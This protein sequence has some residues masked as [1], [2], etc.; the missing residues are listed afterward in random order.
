MHVTKRTNIETVGVNVVSTLS[1]KSND[2]PAPVMMFT[3]PRLQTPREWFDQAEPGF[4]ATERDYLLETASCEDGGYRLAMELPTRY[5]PPEV[6]FAKEGDERKE[7]RQRGWEIIG[8]WFMSQNR[9]YDALAV[10]QSLYCH[11][12]L[13]EHDE[14]QRT[15]K[16]M[17]LIYM[18]ECF[19][20]LRHPVHSKRYLMYTLC[21]DAVQYGREKR[22]KG[23]GVYFR[24]VWHHGMSD[25]LVTEYTQL[26][27]DKAE[28]L[29]EEGWFPERLLAELEDDRWMTESPSEEEV[30]SY[31]CNH[32]YVNHLRA[33]LGSSSGKALE[34]LAH[35]LL[36]M[37][38]G[39]R[40][41]RRQLTPSTDYDVV[42]SFK[43]SGL[44][45]R[46]E[47]GRYF[48]CEYKDWKDPADFTTMA[49][50]A[51]VLDSVKSRFGILFS[52]NW[53]SGMGRTEDAAREQLKV[54]A[55]RGVAIVVVSN[56]DIARVASGEHFLAMIR[57]KYERVRLDIAQPDETSPVAKTPSKAK[58]NKK[59]PEK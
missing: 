54:F 41:Y 53:I 38:P 57:S 46:S 16:G 32:L 26:A 13:H 15:H 33:Q 11:M 21:E 22:A 20:L 19:R 52:K 9:L 27:H 5:T 59:K 51:R 4:N 35:Y 45:F 42:G 1:D 17:P 36:S 50:L 55:D 2:D 56:N 3:L 23:S 47:V 12:L 29:A 58:T 14:H 28:T 43:G 34:Q 37:I 48:V 8:V 30:A 10:F 18:S 49:K 24:A 25:Q 40:A 31:W 6:A 44:D 7:S 39:C